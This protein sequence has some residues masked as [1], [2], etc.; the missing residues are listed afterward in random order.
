VLA[1]AVRAWAT[2]P[3]LSTIWDCLVLQAGKTMMLERPKVLE[4]ADRYGI[5]IVGVV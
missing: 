2:A 4:L 3:L 1:Y 5:V